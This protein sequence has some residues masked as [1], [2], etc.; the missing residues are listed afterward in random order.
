[1]GIGIE[2]EEDRVMMDRFIVRQIDIAVGAK[3]KSNGGSCI[4]DGVRR[5]M[6]AEEKDRA[7]VVG[8]LWERSTY[9]SQL[10]HMQK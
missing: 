8:V 4:V 10:F 5:I 3:R 9:W 7:S 6:G 1:M 2:V